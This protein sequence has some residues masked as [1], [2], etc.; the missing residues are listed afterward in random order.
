MHFLPHNFLQV[1]RKEQLIDLGEVHIY[2]LTQ[3]TFWSSKLTGRV[4][5]YSVFIRVQAPKRV[6]GLYDHWSWSLDN[7]ARDGSVS[8]WI[9][10]TSIVFMM[11]AITL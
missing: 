2:A 11:T 10:T 1:V 7:V 3:G 9:N 8:L 5:C 6:G 4:M